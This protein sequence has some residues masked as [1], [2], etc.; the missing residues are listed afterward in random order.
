MPR[1]A[2]EKRV[3]AFLRDELDVDESQLT[4]ESELVTTGLIDSMDLVSLA[5]FLERSLGI[6]IPDRDI[7]ADHFDS[8][9]KILAYVET[10]LGS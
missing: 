6:T 2:L 4:P 5:T 7:N 3:R 10:K 1:E 9:A 8:I